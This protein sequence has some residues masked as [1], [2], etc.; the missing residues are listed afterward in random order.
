MTPTELYRLSAEQAVDLLQRREISPLELVDAAA[1]RIAATDQHL[2]A[3]PTLCLE[4]ARDHAK[5]IVAGKRPRGM[6]GGLPIAVKDLT[7]VAGVRTTYGSPIYTHHIPVRSDILVERL[8]ANGAIVIGKSNTPEFGAGASTFNEVFGKTRNPWNVEKSVSGSSGGSAAALAAGQAWLATG[9]DLGGSLRTPASFNSIVGLRP[10]PGRVPHGPSELPWNTL[11]VN[12][13]MA[14]TAADVA[15]LLDAMVG[16]HHEDPLSLT[17]P[18][19]SFVQAVRHARAPKRIGY[20]TDLGVVP[21]NPEVERICRQ[22]AQRFTELGAT[23]EEAH[24]D[25]SE[26][27]ECFQTLRATLFA[28]NHLEHLRNHRDQLKPEVVWNIEKG[29]A[30]T[31]AD[32]V[33]AELQRARLYRSTVEFF[34]NYDLLLCPAAIVPPFD[35]DMR[36]VSEVNGQKFDNYIH[37]ISITFVLTLTSCPVLAAPAGFTASN[38]PVG[39]QIMGPPRGEAAVLTAGALLEQ[40]TGSAKLTPVDPRDGRGNPLR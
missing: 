10:S 37:W 12:G 33:K 36:Y 39:V 2:N 24:P 19:Q 8:E 11:S 26:A 30:L 40:T 32:I 6:L 28:A 21:V 29:L 7:D 3:L 23:V 38:L 27:V 31:A 4:R 9:S 5:A 15:L 1:A 20:S 14:R 16:E 17:A 35:V 25:F 22:A 34:Q 18:A 13:P